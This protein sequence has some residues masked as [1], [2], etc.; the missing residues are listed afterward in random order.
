MSAKHTLNVSLTQP[1]RDFV[2]REVRSGRYQTASE[3]F[4][5]PC[6][7]CKANTMGPV[8]KSGHCG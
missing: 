6:V 5:Q 2:D 8:G 1:L 7:S 4:V 3:W